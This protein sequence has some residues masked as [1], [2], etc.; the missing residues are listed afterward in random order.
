LAER[1]RC[2]FGEG[3]C[4]F[5]VCECGFLDLPWPRGVLVGVGE[6]FGDESVL[7][8]GVVPGLDECAVPG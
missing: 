2:G 5:G 6:A 4:G 8:D 7:G 1:N 3:E